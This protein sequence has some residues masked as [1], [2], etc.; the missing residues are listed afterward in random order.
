MRRE[1]KSIHHNRSS[2]KSDYLHSHGGSQI[3]SRTCRRAAREY[4]KQERVYNDPI[5]ENNLPYTEPRER[6][7]QRQKNDLLTKQKIL[8]IT[9][10]WLW[11]PSTTCTYPWYRRMCWRLWNSWLKIPPL[12]SF[13]I[14][15]VVPKSDSEEA[16]AI[17]VQHESV[18]E[19]QVKVDGGVWCRHHHPL[20]LGNNITTSNTR[21]GV[22][23]S[24]LHGRGKTARVP[25]PNR[26]KCCIAIDLELWVAS[27]FGSG[28]NVYRTN[29]IVGWIKQT[30]LKCPVG[31]DYQCIT[32]R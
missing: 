19:T 22:G 13:W 7:L 24:I 3:F 5:Y 18:K 25:E 4:I 26:T 15:L 27:S 11:Q 6:K 10:S 20:F 21:Y 23:V 17:A 2:I 14:L 30:L 9:L 8:S 12:S 16:V 1:A 32:F 28:M 29:P 31:W